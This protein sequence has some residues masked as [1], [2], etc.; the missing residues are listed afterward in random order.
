MLRSLFL[1]RHVE[2][3]PRTISSDNIRSNNYDNSHFSMQSQFSVHS[4]R[5]TL[6]FWFRIVQCYGY[7]CL[8]I[9]PSHH[10]HHHH[11]PPPVEYVIFQGGLSFFPSFH[12]SRILTRTQP[13]LLLTAFRG[14]ARRIALLAFLPGEPFQPPRVGTKA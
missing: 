7:Q 14:A 8:F 5:V 11:H 6:D 12:R 1:C 9:S 2:H 13:C 10:H 3:Y 4:I